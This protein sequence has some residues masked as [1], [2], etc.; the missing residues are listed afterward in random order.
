MVAMTVLPFLSGDFS[1]AE[2]FLGADDS[3]GLIY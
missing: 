3:F 2:R 1:R